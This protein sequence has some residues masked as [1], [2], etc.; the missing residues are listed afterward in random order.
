MIQSCSKNEVKVSKEIPIVMWRIKAVVFLAKCTGFR[1]EDKGTF[2]AKCASSSRELQDKK[3]P[4]EYFLN[5]D[6]CE[7]TAEQLNLYAQQK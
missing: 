7:H 4:N 1:V 2:S 6:I 3:N 5:G